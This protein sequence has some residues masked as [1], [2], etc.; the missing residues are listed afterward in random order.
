MQKT[1]IYLVRNIAMN[2]RTALIFFRCL[3]INTGGGKLGGHFKALVLQ[4]I[5]VIL[6][7]NITTGKA[8]YI[9]HGNG[10][11]HRIAHGSVCAGNIQ[12]RRLLLFYHG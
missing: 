7:H 5:R 11:A 10:Y 9:A 2:I 6:H 8:L 3:Q 12:Y 4:H 1:D